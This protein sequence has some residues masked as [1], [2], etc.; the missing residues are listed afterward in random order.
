MQ[1]IKCRAFHFLPLVVCCVSFRHGPFLLVTRRGQALR[2]GRKETTSLVDQ[3]HEDEEQRDFIEDSQSDLSE[4]M[5]D[6]DSISDAE[7]LLACRAY[8]QRRK[9]WGPWTKAEGRKAMRLRSLRN[10]QQLDDSSRNG[11]F[12]EEPTQLKYLNKNFD[13]PVSGSLSSGEF[14]KDRDPSDENEDEVEEEQSEEEEIWESVKVQ[15]SMGRRDLLPLFEDDRLLDEAAEEFSHFFEGGPSQEHVKRS[16]A[17][18]LMWSDPEWKARWYE[19]RW[20]HREMSASSALRKQRRIEDRLRQF[21][22]NVLENEALAQMNEQEISEAIVEYVRLGKKRKSQNMVIEERGNLSEDFESR[23]QPMLDNNAANVSP[24][25]RFVSD[26]ISEKMDLQNKR[27]ERARKAYT[28]RIENMK[29]TNDPFRQTPKVFRIAPLGDDGKADNR[30]PDEAFREIEKSLNV[31]RVPDMADVVC[32]L[33]PARL[34]GRKELLLRILS[35]CFGLRGKC[36]PPTDTMNQS[37]GSWRFASK[38][39]ISE[40]GDF[41][42]HQLSTLTRDQECT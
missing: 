10:M 7:A 38:V 5:D 41:V 14:S 37:S 4:S 30:S 9:R 27:S 28:T 2:G 13:A 15:G 11:F 40:L 8:L 36:I 12:W 17:K 32:I 1:L 26:D 25:D 21:D 31:V 33:E 6:F 34:R 20:G 29:G 22:P 39:S 16:E 23:T 19:K 42:L 18:K 3:P 35:D 24:L